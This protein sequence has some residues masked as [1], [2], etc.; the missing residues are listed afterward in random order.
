MSL[1][2]ATLLLVFLVTVFVAGPA[3]A[4][5]A[6][7]ADF[8][9]FEDNSDTEG[10]ASTASKGITDATIITAT[11][12]PI[13]SSSSI[14]TTR[15]STSSD[16]STT[17]T[18]TPTP[19]TAGSPAT[20]QTSTTTQTIKDSTTPSPASTDSS[21]SSPT[22]TDSTI[23]SSSTSRIS[24]TTSVSTDSTTASSATAS[25]T[26]DS[27]T[28]STTSVPTTASHQSSTPTTSTSTESS[29]V[30]STI[31]EST[32]KE[33]TTTLSSQPST[34]TSTTSSS[35]AA[36]DSTTDKSTTSVS[37][38][39]STTVTDSSTIESTTKLATTTVSTTA[40]PSTTVPTTTVPTT[41][42]TQLTEEEII[43]TL[44]AENSAAQTVS[45]TLL[46]TIST[47]IWNIDEE[48]DSHSEAVDLVEDTEKL[49]QNKTQE[50]LSWEAEFLQGVVTSI[51]KI[52]SFANRSI[53]TVAQLLSLQKQNLDRVKNLGV[54]L[55]ITGAQILRT[56]K[57][58]DNK[59]SFVKDL[60]LRTIEPKVNS[61]KES[62]A[63]LNVS[64]IN[65]QVELKSVPAVR[66]LTE[67]SIIKLSSLN[68]QVAVLNRTQ[69]NSFDSLKAA[70]KDWAPTNLNA[71]SDLIHAI[72]I[73]QKRTDLAFAICGSS[74]YDLKVYTAHF[75]NYNSQYLSSGSEDSIYR[76]IS[77]NQE[78]SSN[79]DDT[80]P[81]SS[82]S[83]VAAE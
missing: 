44:L 33:S 40:V 57:G 82:W 27:T 81:E 53:D 31:G 29:T 71:V 78:I 39:E 23:D 17:S 49:L 20:I 1:S 46:N 3:L 54:K 65:A 16:S 26:E 6:G 72:S 66:N 9:D 8:P 52:D 60:L 63:N 43:L 47:F 42:A 69:G 77:G 4:Q 70:I 67:T 13:G 32:T 30:S 73:S 28:K 58:L 36:S 51:Q 50:L 80:L 37:I 38:T 10:L 83:I 2:F 41:T 59:L 18:S 74:K 35:A 25:S 5:T 14:S 11:P 55:N 21:T 64:Q 76:G 22:S 24:T 79:E 75:E 7:V 62:F 56:S 15:S 19:S 61:L 68:N 12:I 45:N 48:L 34:T